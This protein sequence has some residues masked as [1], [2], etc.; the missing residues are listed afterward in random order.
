MEGMLL[1]EYIADMLEVRIPVGWDESVGI[2]CLQDAG[3][4]DYTEDE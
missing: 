1:Q 4:Q 2:R 3:D